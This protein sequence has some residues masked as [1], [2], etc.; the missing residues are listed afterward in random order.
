MRAFIFRH[1]SPLVRAATIAFTIS[2]VA[3]AQQPSAPPQRTAA[4]Q[5]KPSIGPAA[6][7]ESAS[8]VAGPR[9]EAGPILRWFD[10]DAYRDLWITPVRVPVLNLQTFVPGGLKPVKEGGG[11]QT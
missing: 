1:A 8:V 6:P 7:G 3:Q 4:G 9:Y 5:L 2:A 11:M 10:G